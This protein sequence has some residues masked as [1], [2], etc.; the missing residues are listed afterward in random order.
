MIG[1]PLNKHY[2]QIV[3]QNDLKYCPN[4]VGDVKNTK[5][6]CGPYHPGLEEWSTRKIP[7]CVSSDRIHIPKEYYKLVKS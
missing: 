5:A 4:D 6:I 7:K 3:S 1:H 2:K